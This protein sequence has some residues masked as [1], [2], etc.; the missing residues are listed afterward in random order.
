MTRS[1]FL[2]ALAS[3]LYILISQQ[4]NFQH[5]AD[6]MV[7][8]WSVAFLLFRVHSLPVSLGGK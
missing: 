6:A 2:H 1:K 8:T 3:N 5:S 4:G 7:T